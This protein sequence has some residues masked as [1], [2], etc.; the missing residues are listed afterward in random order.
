[1]VIATTT[2]GL[3]GEDRRERVLFPPVLIVQGSIPL[4]F[5]LHIN[6]GS[7]NSLNL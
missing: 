7:Y 6:I 3:L 1:M 5:L 4:P 2:E